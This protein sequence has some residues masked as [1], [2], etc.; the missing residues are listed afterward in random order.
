[1]KVGSNVLSIISIFDILP[2]GMS[3]QIPVNVVHALL[4]HQGEESSAGL[5]LFSGPILM[6]IG[7][8]GLGLSAHD[9]IDHF[10]GVEDV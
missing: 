8:S 5:S 3:I 6:W 2:D 4:A 9:E 10:V 7:V 1:M